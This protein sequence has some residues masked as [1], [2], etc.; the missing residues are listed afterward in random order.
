[1]DNK[2]FCTH[3]F[4]IENNWLPWYPCPIYFI[5][6]IGGEFTDTAFSHRYMLME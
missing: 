3:Q 6:N 5:H 2:S 1:M 4:V